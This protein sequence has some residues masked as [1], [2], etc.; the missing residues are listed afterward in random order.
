MAQ[1][2]KP[3]VVLRTLCI[4]WIVVLAVAELWPGFGLWLPGKNSVG[5]L[6]GESVLISG[7]IKN[8]ESGGRSQQLILD[9]LT[10]DSKLVSDQLLIFTPHFPEFLY[11]QI[12]STRCRLEAPQPFNGFRYDRYLAA[13]SVYATCFVNDPPFVIGESGNYFIG[14]LLDFRQVTLQRIDLVFI[15]VASSNIFLNLIS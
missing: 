13:K 9:H 10:I 14:Q 3:S 1:A 7:R 11:G 6:V 8:A 5:Q 12:I 4:I 15:W 2:I